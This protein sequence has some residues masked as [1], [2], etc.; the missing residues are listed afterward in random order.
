MVETLITNKELSNAERKAMSLA[1]VVY[2]YVRNTVENDELRE[3]LTPKENNREIRAVGIGLQRRLFG[4][5]YSTYKTDLYPHA[6]KYSVDKGVYVI[7]K[8]TEDGFF[9]IKSTA[10]DATFSGQIGGLA[11]PELRF[12]CLAKPDKSG[13][14]CR[15]EDGV[16]RTYY[17]IGNKNSQLQSYLYFSNELNDE[18]LQYEY[19]PKTKHALERIDRTVKRINDVIKSN[20][21]RQ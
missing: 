5:A 11:I 12:T 4:K 9:E 1:I 14:F 18:I 17:Q 16:R 10:S 2:D 3:Q 20:F 15:F 13:Q 19:D 6:G 7:N 8:P 21:S